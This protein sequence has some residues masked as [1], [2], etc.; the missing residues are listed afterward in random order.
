MYT[1]HTQLYIYT[2]THLQACSHPF[3][4][5]TRTHLQACSHPLIVFR[6]ESKLR[7]GVV[8][9]RVKAGGD[10]HKLW[11]EPPQYLQERKEETE[12]DGE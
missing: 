2:R 6:H 7:Q 1:V 12:R 11:S 4:V 9:V 10:D 8:L 3:I 5:Y